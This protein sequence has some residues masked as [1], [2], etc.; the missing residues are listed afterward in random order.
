[1]K[2]LFGPS[3]NSES[4][5]DEGNKSSVEAPGWLKAK[6]LDAYEYS[7]TKGVK[8]KE[9]TAEEIGQEAEKHGIFLSI[10]APYYINLANPDSDKRKNSIGYI[11]DSLQAARWMGAKRV[12]FHPGSCSKVSRRKAL[13]IAKETLKF[14]MDQAVE[15]GLDDIS[16]CPE[17]LGKKNQLGNLEE[18]IELCKLDKRFVPALDFGHIHAFNLGGLT[19]DADYERVFQTIIKELGEDRTR[20]LHIHYSRIEYTRSGEKKHWTYSDTQYGPEFEPLARCLKK[21]DVSAVIICE[22]R[23]TMAEDAVK[24]KEIYN[25]ILGSGRI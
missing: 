9:K 25:N 10:H 3:G 13:E 23:G 22:S 21:F 16:L 24:L 8:I 12:V 18:V 20:N 15:R 19:E 11:M 2:V 4:F 17:T 5:Y 14:A 1:M 7:C 6:G